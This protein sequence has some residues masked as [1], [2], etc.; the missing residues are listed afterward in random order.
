MTAIAMA[1]LTVEPRFR[2]SNQARVVPILKSFSSSVSS[3][4]VLGV[5]GIDRIALRICLPLRLLGARRR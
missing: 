2:R 4:L 1:T 5:T 3:Q